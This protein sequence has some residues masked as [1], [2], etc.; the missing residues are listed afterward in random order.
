MRHVKKNEPTNPPLLVARRYRSS[1]G[2]ELFLAVEDTLGYLY[3]FA[4]LLLPDVGTTLDE[5]GL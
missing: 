3:G 5:P 4:R 1:N 2:E